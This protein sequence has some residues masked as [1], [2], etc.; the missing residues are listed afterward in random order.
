M[1]C[2]WDKNA[3][4]NDVFEMNLRYVVFSVLLK[5]L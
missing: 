2:K 3:M 5:Q 1:N 4:S